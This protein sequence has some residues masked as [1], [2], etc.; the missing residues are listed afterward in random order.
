MKKLNYELTESW[1]ESHVRSWEA[2]TNHL[3]PKTYLEIGSYE[4]GSLIWF[5]TQISNRRKDGVI[6]CIDSWQGG[7][8][9]DRAKMDLVEARFDKNLDIIKKNHAIEITK[10]RDQSYLA[11]ARMLVNHGLE[12]FFDLVLIDG[13]HQS[14][15][16]ITDLCLAYRLLKKNG[17]LILDDYIWRHPLGILHEP[18]LAIDTFT[19]IY[20]DRLA[21][22]PDIPLRQVALLKLK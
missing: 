17:V 13:S 6:Y 11:M 1:F 18:K 7:E 19:N 10:I 22:I 16:V 9:H 4:G 21:F 12:E 2:I 14:H 5:A 20:R 15:D 8:E 3:N